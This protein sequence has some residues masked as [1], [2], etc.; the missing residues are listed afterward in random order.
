ML[1]NECSAEFKET[2]QNNN[3]KYQLVLPNDHRCNATEKAI[4]T[5][6]D[7]F[8]AVLSGTDD[9]FPLQRW[10]QILTQTEHQLYM[11]RKSRAVPNMSAF[12]HM[13]GR[14]SY[15]AHHWAVLGCKVEIHTMPVQQQTKGAHTK[16]GYYMGTSCEHYRCH[17]VC[18]A[19]QNSKPDSNAMRAAVNTLVKFFVMR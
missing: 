11:L 1:D 2:I 7:H 6:K 16:M 17:E 8:V 13:C 19:L 3:M 10:C 12:E 18:G 14:H 9:T 5:F 15:D 4:Q